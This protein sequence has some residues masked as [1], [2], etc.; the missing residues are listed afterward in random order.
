M[1]SFRDFWWRR[2]LQLVDLTTDAAIVLGIGIGI[3]SLLAI[4][5]GLL[6]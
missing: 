3:G 1:S 6:R 2:C 5:T 4:V